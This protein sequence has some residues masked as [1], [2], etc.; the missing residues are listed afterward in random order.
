M[1][2]LN[3]VL[4]P[5]EV[6]ERRPKFSNMA[7]FGAPLVEFT[8][9]LIAWTLARSVLIA[10]LLPSA[11]EAETTARWLDWAYWIVFAVLAAR[12]TWRMGYRAVRLLFRELAVTDRR[13]MEK[14]G[15]VNVRFWSTD[16]EKIV[17]VTIEQPLLGRFFDYGAVTIVTIGEVEHTT[18]GIA[19][20][21]D[22]QQSV[23]ARMARF[24]DGDGGLAPVSGRADS[25]PRSDG[26]AE[27]DPHAPLRR[28]ADV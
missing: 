20:P 17:R 24:A 10:W 1:G 21:I 15:V 27:A 3:K 5:G 18:S 9:F 16:L 8:L 23:H 12:F 4:L 28:P 11:S 13:F 6:I 14:D 25:E 2:Y 19:S 7:Q 26:A 22:L